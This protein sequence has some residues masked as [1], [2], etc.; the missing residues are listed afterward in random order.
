ML[1]IR[2]HYSNEIYVTR[3]RIG[4]WIG[5]GIQDQK[6]KRQSPTE[7]SEVIQYKLRS[8]DKLFGSARLFHFC[9][10]QKSTPLIHLSKGGKISLWSHYCGTN[11]KHP[12]KPSRR[13]PTSKTNPIG[14]ATET[15]VRTICGLRINK[16][17]PE[18]ARAQTEQGV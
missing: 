6:T 12:A 5:V 2:L 17:T 11:S 7:Y 3:N 16:Y 18:G 10:F 8:L 14:L 4:T 13:G 15:L 1:G 9:V